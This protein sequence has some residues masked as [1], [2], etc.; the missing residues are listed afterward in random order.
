M[1]DQV[2]E[3]SVCKEDVLV[4]ATSVTFPFVCMKCE[5]GDTQVSE[6]THSCDSAT[7]DNTTEL[8]ADLELQ[9]ATERVR[10]AE[11][12]IR[13][14]EAEQKALEIQ[15]RLDLQGKAFDVALLTLGTVSADCDH[16]VKM[17]ET[18]ITGWKKLSSNRFKKILDL[19]DELAY[20]RA[21]AGILS[22]MVTRTWESSKR[23]QAMYLRA[24]RSI[25]EKIADWF[26]EQW[27][28]CREEEYGR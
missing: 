17:Y 11:A 26:R 15:G 18:R 25:P 9:L 5:N 8:I 3:C 28:D 16:K 14:G 13:A 1:I 24:S 4:T 6:E 7:I 23:F 21:E 22:G 2:I 19:E 20:L 12:E 10:A 27:R